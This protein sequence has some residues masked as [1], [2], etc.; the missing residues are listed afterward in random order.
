MQLSSAELLVAAPMRSSRSPVAALASHLMAA[1]D[2]S[3]AE[4]AACHRTKH[5]V[6]V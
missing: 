1:D 6:V 2:F 5:E 4:V 3:L